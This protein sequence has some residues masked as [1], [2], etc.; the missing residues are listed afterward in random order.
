M[1]HSFP[2]IRLLPP[3]NIPIKPS[4]SFE[5]EFSR[6]MSKHRPGFTL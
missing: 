4:F 2:F 1:V 3:E 5:S 6:N